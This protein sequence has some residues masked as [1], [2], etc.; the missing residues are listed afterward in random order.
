MI[1]PYKNLLVT[2]G[3][4]Y[5][6]SKFCYDA[7]DKGFNVVIIDN[8]STGFKKLIPKKSI[9]YKYDINNNIKIDEVLKKHNINCVVHFA[10]SLNVKESMLDPLKYYNNNSIATQ[11]LINISIKNNF[12]KF[13]YSSSAAVYGNLNST[14]V[15]SSKCLPLSHYGMSKLLAENLLIKKKRH[16]NFS[17]GI[18]I[19][20]NLVGADTKLRTGLMNKND[21]LLSNLVNHSAKL[22]KK[23]K[24]YGN[25]YSTH[26]GT[27]LR[28]YIDI[29]DLSNIHIEVIKKIKKNQKL[30]LNCSYGKVYSVLE[31]I[32]KFEKISKNQ[33]KIIFDS[34]RPGDIEKIQT[35]NKKLLKFMKKK[36]KY[37]IIKSLRLSLKW[38]RK[39]FKN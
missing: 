33:F 15:E 19:Y 17:L 24:I 34:P 9:F 4:G 23:I 21:S 3:A 37:N 14:I 6:G 12:K 11:N 39:I 29:N 20:F 38:H 10:G 27:C 25:N 16:H 7:L 1:F 30:I 2:G 32:N 28:D 13:I 35:N 8:L 36:F 18:F 5:I 22:Q 26:D 31:V